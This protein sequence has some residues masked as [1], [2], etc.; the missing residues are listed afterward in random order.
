MIEVRLNADTDGEIH[1]L[2]PAR[3]APFALWRVP[4][5]GLKLAEDC[6]QCEVN[7]A[8]V[9][10][11]FA[12][13]EVGPGIGQQPLQLLLVQ[14]VDSLQPGRDGGRELLVQ[15]EVEA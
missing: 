2:A 6:G 15:A 7:V 12:P 10:E 8:Q 1:P 5:T 11:I 9:V 14:S 3:A 4:E 13:A